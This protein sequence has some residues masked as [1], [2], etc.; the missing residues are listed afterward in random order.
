MKRLMKWVLRVCGYQITRIRTDQG[1]QTQGQQRRKERMTLAD[2]LE[3]IAKLSREVG[4]EPQTVIDVG[5]ADGTP[6]LYMTFPR[7]KLL[8]VEPLIEFEDVLKEICTQ[9]D[10]Q[11]VLAATASQKG[12]TNINITPDLHGSSI[13]DPKEPHLEFKTR[14]VPTVTIDNLVDELGLEGPFILKVDA[15]SAE[16]H[17]L[18]GASRTM[19]MSEVIFLESQLFQFVENGPQLF[20]IVAFLKQNGFVVYDIVGRNYRLLDRALAEVDVAF[21]KENGIFRSSH[22][23]AS[24]EQ[25]KQQFAEPDKRY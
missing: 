19:E 2:A 5:V 20:D 10:A 9:Y 3:H 13:L 23:F 7:S 18:S 11:Y 17:V 1:Q 14:E 6:E 21:V 4:F 12:T 22:L 15:Q 8:L 16:F 24:S 25:R